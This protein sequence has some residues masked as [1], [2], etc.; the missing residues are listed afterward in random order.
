MQEAKQREAE[1]NNGARKQTSA[2]YFPSSTTVL[3][4]AE[5]A[6]LAVCNA[7]SSSMVDYV[8]RLLLLSFQQTTA[9]LKLHYTVVSCA[10]HSATS[11]GIQTSEKLFNVPTSMDYSNHESLHLLHCIPLTR[12]NM[13]VYFVNG[14]FLLIPEKIGGKENG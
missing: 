13:L 6:N 14:S 5:W 11:S 2:R 10:T 12:C 8:G 7:A 1:A 3:L 4:S 9:V